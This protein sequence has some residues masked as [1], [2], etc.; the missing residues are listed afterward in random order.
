MQSYLVLE[1]QYDLLV[2]E[3][4]TSSTISPH[5]A[6]V[7]RNQT[8]YGYKITA[9][10]SDNASNMLKAFTTTKEGTVQYILSKKIMHISCGAHTF[11]LTIVDAR[12]N[13]PDFAAI[14]DQT[15]FF[16]KFPEKTS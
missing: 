16:Y 11:Q 2:L 14:F 4:S 13:F 6:D 8:N 3:K 9:V 12:K 15:L 7:Y 10:T 5:V 1:V